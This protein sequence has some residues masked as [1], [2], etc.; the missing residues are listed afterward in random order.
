M[1]E[2]RDQMKKTW[3]KKSDDVKNGSLLESGAENSFGN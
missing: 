3:V 1:D 2:I